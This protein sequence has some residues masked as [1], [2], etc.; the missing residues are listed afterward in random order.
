MIDAGDLGKA[1]GRSPALPSMP[2]VPIYAPP[3]SGTIP[4]VAPVCDLCNRAIESG[5]GRVNIKIT[6]PN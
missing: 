3:V 2:V 5:P 6:I 4:T 1:P